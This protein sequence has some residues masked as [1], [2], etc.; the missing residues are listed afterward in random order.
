[1]AVESNVQQKPQSASSLDPGR[2]AEMQRDGG[3]ELIDVRQADEWEAGHIG[4]SRH[5]VLEELPS[6]AN[7]IARDRPVVFHCRSG[8]RS[9]M[10]A[11]AFQLADYDAYN[12]AGG[13][14]AWQDA[15]LPLEPEGARVSERSSR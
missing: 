15:G 1:M 11:D 6:H 9:A 12:M 7:S 5:I 8:N 13:L 14:L 4:G 2:V 3:V 10:V